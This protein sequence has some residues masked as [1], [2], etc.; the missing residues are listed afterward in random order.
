MRTILLSVLLVLNLSFIYPQ[1]K[2]FYLKPKALEMGKYDSKKV[3]KNKFKVLYDKEAHEIAG[4]MILQ[5]NE[6]RNFFWG[7]TENNEVKPD[8]L[9]F[10]IKKYYPDLGII[11]YSD[12]EINDIYDLKNKKNV[13]H[14]DPSTFAYSPSGKY[15]LSYL[16]DDVDRYYLEEKKNGEYK[17]LGYVS[18]KAWETY[19]GFYWVDDNTVHF[20]KEKQKPDGIKYWIGYSSRFY[21]IPSV[22]N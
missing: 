19:S 4:N 5:D 18:L 13:L 2:W 14:G 6:L 8:M 21:Q 1:E 20:L 17:L 11:V 10:D 7:E 15:R 9:E 12:V 16:I 3:T 22:N